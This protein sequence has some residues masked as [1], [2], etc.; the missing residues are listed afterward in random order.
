MTAKQ[1]KEYM[2]E[3]N[4]LNRWLLPEAGLC[5]DNDNLGKIRN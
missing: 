2:K 1:T 4:A 3:T 5:K